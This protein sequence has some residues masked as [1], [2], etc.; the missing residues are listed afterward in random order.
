MAGRREM[1]RSIPLDRRK[2]QG[3][4]FGEKIIERLR[5][6]TKLTIVLFLNLINLQTW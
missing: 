2:D 6:T 5:N 4:M 3:G 1:P